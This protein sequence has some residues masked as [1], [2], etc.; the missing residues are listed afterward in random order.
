MEQRKYSLAEI[1]SMCRYVSDI[2][3]DWQYSADGKSASG[4][5]RSSS[6]V[7]DRLRT[8]M[9]NGT[10]PDELR[11]RAQARHEDAKQAARSFAEQRLLLQG[12]IDKHGRG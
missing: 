4:P 9:L 12:M 1:D 2:L 5:G 10:E 3:T 8:Y 7:E 11:E 6:E